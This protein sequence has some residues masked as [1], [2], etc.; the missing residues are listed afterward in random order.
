[1]K[2]SASITFWLG[3]VF[4]LLTAGYGVFGWLQLGDMPPGQER[5]DARGYVMFWMFLG[6]IGVA[7]A[8]VSWW[9]AR[10]ERG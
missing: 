3:V 7:C 4:T 2:F 8:M 5:D 9:I 1:M 10:T 6:A